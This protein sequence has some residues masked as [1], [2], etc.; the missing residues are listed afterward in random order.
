MSQYIIIF[1]SECGERFCYEA[2]NCGEYNSHLYF[3]FVVLQ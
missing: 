1:S 2:T 3:L